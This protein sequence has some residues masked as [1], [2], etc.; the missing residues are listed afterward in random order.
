M[1]F[2]MGLTWKFGNDIV[3]NPREIENLDIL[4]FPKGINLIW[5]GISISTYLLVRL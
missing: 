1:Q 2:G 4:P 3:E 5:R